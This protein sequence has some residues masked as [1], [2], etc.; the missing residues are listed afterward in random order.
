MNDIKTP[1]FVSPGLRPESALPSMKAPA[2]SA[3]V[4]KLA[5]EFS[6][7]L[8][9]ELVKSM[10]AT[11]SNEGLAGDTSSSRDSYLSLADVEVSR[12]LAKRDGMGLAAFLE[13]ALGKLLPKTERQEAS[14]VETAQHRTPVGPQALLGR[15]RP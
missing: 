10:R 7:L 15:S 1:S 3:D 14:Q 6:S 5:G 11:L 9:A 12:A 4:K 8:M 13:R 2:T